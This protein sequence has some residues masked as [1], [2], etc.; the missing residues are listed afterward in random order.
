MWSIHI[1]TSCEIWFGATLM[2]IETVTV[3][4]D[5]WILHCYVILYYI[6]SFCKIS[7][8]I[9]RC[10]IAHWNRT[11]Y[12]LSSSLLYIVWCIYIY[13]C[14]IC[15]SF[16][17]L[18]EIEQQFVA[19]HLT[20]SHLITLHYIILYGNIF[21]ITIFCTE[22]NCMVMLLIFEV[23]SSPQSS[24][25]CHIPSSYI[26]LFWMFSNSP[27]SIL[28][29]SEEEI[30]IQGL[31]DGKTERPGVPHLTLQHLGTNSLIYSSFKLSCLHFALFSP[32]LSYS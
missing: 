23:L 20:I 11:E 14:Y 8:Y 16:N 18:C 24:Y 4:G 22:L 7:P 1:I 9:A 5:G 27:S 31:G 19:L 28:L 12:S 32:L 21:Y 10:C 30:R 15:I 26:C 17:I 25:L 6:I 2:R 29:F 3:P 13:T